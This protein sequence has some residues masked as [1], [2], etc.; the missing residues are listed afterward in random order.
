MESLL[1]LSK[2][3]RERNQVSKEI[4]QIIGRPAQIGHV[5]EFI[6]SKLFDIRL[7]HSAV[8][9]GIDGVFQSGPLQGK[10]VN[11]KYY[12][13][14]E[15][16]LDINP[17]AIAEYYLVLT[18]PQTKVA[19]SRGESRL[20]SIDWVFLLDGQHLHTELQKRGVKI[21]I[22]TSVTQ[23]Y[24]NECEVYPQPRSSILQL[25]ESKVSIL[26]AFHSSVVFS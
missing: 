22:A 3:I 14:R 25:D 18:G 12:G 17:G 21:G 26:Q 11:I 5:G 7:E 6:A 10:S 9:K 19:H 23:E 24:W 8:A 4:T 15:G 13:K 20:W 16:L 1:A 2:L